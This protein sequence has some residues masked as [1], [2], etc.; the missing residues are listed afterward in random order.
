MSVEDLKLLSDSAEFIR[1]GIYKVAFNE[2]LD[3][4][5]YYKFVK[6]KKC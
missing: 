1:L 6:E 3:H 5:F 2:S 4:L